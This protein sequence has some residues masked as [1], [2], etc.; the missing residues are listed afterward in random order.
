S[1]THRTERPRCWSALR[2][3]NHVTPAASR[4]R[5]CHFFGPLK[6]EEKK[7]EPKL[8][9]ST[10]RSRRIAGV[11]STAKRKRAGHTFFSRTRS[12]RKKESRG[13]RGQDSE[14]ISLASVRESDRPDEEENREQSAAS[15]LTLKR[16]WRE[17]E[18]LWG[19]ERTKE[20]SS[21]LD[22]TD[23]KQGSRH[24]FV[25]LEEKQIREKECAFAFQ[26]GD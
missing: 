23:A 22:E 18:R 17:D 6:G 1:R 8:K 25:N 4:S 20:S 2:T 16:R 11:D 26:G 15:L 9:E 7:A 13:R 24:D 19:K 10:R 12:E 5:K 21:R 14:G 3:P